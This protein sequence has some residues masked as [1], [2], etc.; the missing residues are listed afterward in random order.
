[1]KLLPYNTFTLQTQD[2]LPI[3]LEKLA[4]HIEPSKLRWHISRH[5]APYE[6]TLSE[7]G[8]EIHRIIHYR[9][10]FVPIIRGRFELS[11]SGTII[12]ITMKLH[13]FVIAFLV[14]WYVTWYSF[15][16]PMC[17]AGAMPAD[18]ALM[19]LGMPITILFAFWCAFWYE[20]NRSRRDLVQIILGEP[21]QGLNSGSSRQ[22]NFDTGL[23]KAFQVGVFL[24]GIASLVWSIVAREFFP[25]T[26]PQ[27]AS[28]EAVSCSQH[29]TQSPYC[30]FSVVR[31]IDGH[32]SA[33]T[34]AI[35]A[36]GQTLVSGGQDKAIKV[37]DLKTGQ[38][39]KTLQSDSGQ[40]R[41]VAIAP[42]GKIV[43]S[44]SADHMVRIWNLTKD[45]PPRMLKGHSD[46]VKLVQMT[47]DGKT[48]ISGSNGAVKEWDLATGQ[49]KATLP[50]LRKSEIKIGPLSIEDDAMER[51]IPLA[52]NPTSKTA[53]VEF[54]GG[55]IKV[56]DLTTNQQTA[57]LKERFDT[58]AG[59]I[60]SAYMSPDGKT[61]A[62]QYT[63]SSK[64]FE[65]RLKV[66]DLTTG[67]V[68]AR[69]STFFS[70]DTFVNVPLALSRDRIFGSTNRQLR[71]WNLQTAE[72]EAVL[73]TGWM[74]ALAVSPD[75]KLL[76]G[77]S[78]NP[79]SQNAQ[80][81]VLRR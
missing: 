52:I 34:L 8:F 56:W 79:D 76:A 64:K 17:L 28:L 46:D 65:T 44:G 75:G 45:Q 20:A 12:R 5:H 80:I 77:I 6:G 48:L 57:I 4:A 10:S 15:S 61:A 19:F 37:W 40:V 72:L 7:T 2:P 18:F 9:N 53:I 1:M 74:D 41:A 35:S 62:L 33:S 68:A 23:P 67:K 11:P 22:S 29:P 24:I 78:V 27:L 16:L 81:K 30:K 66:W 50:N 38:L 59:Y 36:D 54:L 51:L 31:T 71:V 69:G 14:F 70:R 47:P 73:D 63:N 26:Q 39:K 3:V 42:D 49:L 60:L 32:P 13:P 25:S 58:F 43:V 21:S 55:D